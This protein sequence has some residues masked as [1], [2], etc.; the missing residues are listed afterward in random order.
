MRSGGGAIHDPADSQEARSVNAG[1]RPS[2]LEYSS[3]VPLGRS[4][5]SKLSG[6]NLFIHVS[7]I[8]RVYDAH[9][10]VLLFSPEEALN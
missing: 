1:R 8:G 5:D 7:P 10:N 2:T 3:Y 9:F 6:F 4:A